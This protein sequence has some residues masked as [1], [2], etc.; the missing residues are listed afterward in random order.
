MPSTISTSVSSALASSTV[1][2]PSLPTFC[3]A[4]RDHLADRRVAVRG[5]G[6]DLGDFGDELTFLERFLM[7]S[8]T[9]LTAISMPRL[10]SIGFMPAATDLTPSLTMAAASTVAVVVPSPASVVGLLRDFAHHLRA[11]I[12]ELVFELDLLGDGDAVLGDARRAVGFVDDDVAALGAERHFHR[13]GEH[14]DAAQHAVARVGGKSYVFRRHCR[15][16]PWVFLFR[17]GP[18]SPGLSRRSRCI[19]RRCASQSRWPEQVRP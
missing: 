12:L 13:I 14:L 3:I 18:S 7:S 1:M 17:F 5:N 4:S 6:A 16:A 19:W 11:H 9:A 10:R 2:T 8:T 15:V